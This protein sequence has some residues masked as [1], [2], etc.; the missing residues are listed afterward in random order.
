M[1]SVELNPLFHKSLIKVNYARCLPA[2]SKTSCSAGF[3]PE[4][5]REDDRRET[6]PE[7]MK[8]AFSATSGGKTPHVRL[9]LHGERTSRADRRLV[10]KRGEFELSGDF[11]KPFSKPL[12]L[13]V[14]DE[15][16][17]GGQPL[18]RES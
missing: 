4:P 11:V 2:W 3:P 13:L 14:A 8:G 17:T 1:S 6:I 18:Q 15:K 7:T 16:L 9:I 10:G 12:P 5:A